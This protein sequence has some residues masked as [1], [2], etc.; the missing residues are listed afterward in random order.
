M[1]SIMLDSSIYVDEQKIPKWTHF[2]ERDVL[3]WK[4]LL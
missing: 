4:L 3:H 2:T 1:N